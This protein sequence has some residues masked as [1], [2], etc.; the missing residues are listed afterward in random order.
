M[1]EVGAVLTKQ[2]QQVRGWLCEGALEVD[3]RCAFVEPGAPV[4][5]RI[6]A[7]RPRTISWFNVL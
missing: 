1:R 2:L 3:L 4:V 7:L 6:Q 5:R